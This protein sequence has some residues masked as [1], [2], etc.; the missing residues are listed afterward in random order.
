MGPRRGLD[1]DGL[2]VGAVRHDDAV[3]APFHRGV[4][5]ADGD[6][7][8]VA[9]VGEGRMQEERGE[10]ERAHAATRANVVP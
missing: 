5:G 6:E 1:A 8:Q 10:D 7:A 4:A 3:E 2:A 9:V